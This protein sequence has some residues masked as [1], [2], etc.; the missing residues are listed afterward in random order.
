M[1]HGAQQWKQA[2]QVYADWGAGWECV[3]WGAWTGMQGGLWDQCRMGMR[4]WVVF[5]V[6]L[7]VGGWSWWLV[8]VVD[9]GPGSCWLRVVL[10]VGGGC[11]RWW[12]SW[13]LVVGPGLWWLVPVVGGWSGWLGVGP[14]GWW[15]VL[16]VGG[17]SWWLA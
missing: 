5:G 6:V 4:S 16:V 14:D 1:R 3:V 17:W 2:G 10:V 8:L 11:G 13:W 12:R 15:L 7:V 9:G